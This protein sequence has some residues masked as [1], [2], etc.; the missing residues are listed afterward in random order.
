VRAIGRS[1]ADD[2]GRGKFLLG[3]PASTGPRTYE[4]RQW[5]AAESVRV[6][7]YTRDRWAF[8]PFAELIEMMNLEGRD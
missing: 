4:R 5:L 1:F 6:P 7:L 8:R 3:G 2:R